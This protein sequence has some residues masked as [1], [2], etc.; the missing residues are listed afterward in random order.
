MDDATIPRR[1][2]RLFVSLEAQLLPQESEVEGFSAFGVGL[3][4]FVE[5][6]IFQKFDDGLASP[7][8]MNRIDR[9]A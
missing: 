6:V 9:S 4:R 1:R 7:G 2:S 8:D 3:A 5:L